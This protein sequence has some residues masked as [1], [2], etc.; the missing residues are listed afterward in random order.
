MHDLLDQM[1]QK[2][3]ESIDTDL[4]FELCRREGIESIV[5]GSFVKAGE[6]YEA[7]L[8]LWKDAVPDL[9]EVEEA[10][11]RLASLRSN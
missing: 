4:G 9:P 10:K 5:T 7:F 1:G 2:G 11:K 8:E 6:Q 3:V